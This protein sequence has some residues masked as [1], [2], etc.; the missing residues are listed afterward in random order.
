[1]W[2]STSEWLTYLRGTPSNSMVSEKVLT[3]LSSPESYG[4][5]YIEYAKGYFFAPVDGVYR[6]SVAADDDFL[7]VM[8]TVKNNANISNLSPLLTQ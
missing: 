3:E 4:E 7:M 5:N 8:S 2:K 1:M 6:F